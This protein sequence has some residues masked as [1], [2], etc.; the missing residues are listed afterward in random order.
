MLSLQ[1]LCLHSY[2]SFLETECKTW[3][4]LKRSKSR[5]LQSVSYE[6]LP[7]L[8]RHL[9]SFLSGISSSNTRELMINEILSGKYPSDKYRNCVEGNFEGDTHQLGLFD[10]FHRLQDDIVR[11]TKR[12]V[13]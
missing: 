5:L 13:R 12:C 7:T 2:L 4:D 3:I 10:S 11:H 8:Q 9:S 6:I 1:N